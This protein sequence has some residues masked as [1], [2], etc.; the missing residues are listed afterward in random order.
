MKFSRRLVLVYTCIVV[1][2]LVIIVICIAT[3]IRKSQ[4]SDLRSQCSE[5]LDHNVMLINK[6]LD[7]FDLIERMI[8]GN[9]KLTLF[10]AT[11]ETSDENEIIN[12]MIDEST[13]IERTLSVLP[14]IYAV[15]VFTDNPIIPERWPVFM[16]SSRTN[17]AALKKWEYNYSAKYQGNQE[18]M[19]LLSLCTTRRIVKNRRNIGYIQIAMKMEDFFSFLYERTDTYQSDYV[20]KEF[21]NPA[22]GT[23]TL[24]PVVNKEILRIQN[25]LDEKDI[26]SLAYA[27]NYAGD[28]P[29]GTLTL[30]GNHDKRFVAWR[31]I[32]DLGYIVVHADSTA[33]IRKNIIIIELIII[34]GLFGTIVVLFLLIRFAT[35]RLMSGV[36][37]V[38]NGMKEV[39]EGNLE[40]SVLVDRHDEVGE[41]QQ[42]FNAM[43]EQLRAQIKQI[44]EEQRLIADTEI[45]A[46]QNQINAH[47]LYNVLETIRMQAVIANQDDIAESITVLGKMMR[48]CLRWRIHVVTLEQEIE[49]IRLYVYILNVRNDYV[50]S[51]ETEIPPEYSSVEIPKMI[52]QPLIENAF[53]HAI[54]P[55]GKDTVVKVYVKQV[56]QSDRILLCVQDF[57]CG[58]SEAQLEKIRTYLADDTYEH[59]AKGG[60]GLKNIQQRLTM[61]YGKDYRLQIDSVAGEGTLVQVPVP[62]HLPA[63]S[64]LNAPDAQER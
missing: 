45:K 34:A 32:P 33:R 21:H 2:P 8:S 43:T 36:Y 53:T 28:R 11:P 41:T 61:F 47:F 57:G 39:K 48:Y 44:K 29:S 49:Y 27:V 31:R 26:A 22:D 3:Y 62:L 52:M 56:P 5:V 9:Q 30:Y 1:I 63:D 40:V 54:E 55:A 38:M 35:S 15:R 50:I 51:L 64:P 13:M 10:F 23:E 20:F 16:K 14:D 24:T 46:M 19:K 12:T 37:S 17:L 60:I 18:A 25:S 42:T 59:N 6:N 7:S 58:M 4:Y